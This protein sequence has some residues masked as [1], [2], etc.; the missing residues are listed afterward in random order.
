M[1]NPPKIT[2]IYQ[3][4]DLTVNRS[5]KSFFKRRFTKWYSNEIHG[6]LDE[7]KQIDQVE[8]LLCLLVLKPLDAK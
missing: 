3:R 8:V 4:L 1:K 7:N 5:A 2:H 6:Q